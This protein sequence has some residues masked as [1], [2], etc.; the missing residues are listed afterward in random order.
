[1]P[2]QSLKNNRKRSTRSNNSGIPNPPQWSSTVRF[3]YVQ[4][5]FINTAGGVSQRAITNIDIFDLKCACITA[6]TAARIFGGAKLNSIECWAANSSATASNTLVVEMFTNN[7]NLG[8]SSKIFSDTAVGTSN[9]AHVKAKPPKGSFSA[10][11]LPNV[12]GTEYTVFNLTGPQGTIIDINMTIELNDDETALFVLG[13]FAAGT[14]GTIYTR[15]LDS[16]NAA[17]HITP[18]GVI[19]N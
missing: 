16:T 13:A 10:D 8:S 11:W 4:R 14:P 12:I 6:A 1:M 2:K 7:P 3:N 9:V 17:P 19:T 5:F 18:L 15:A